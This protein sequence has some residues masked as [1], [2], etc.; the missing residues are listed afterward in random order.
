MTPLALIGLGAAI[1]ADLGS[2]LTDLLLV[3]PGNHDFRRLRNGDS[4]ALRRL[5]HNVVAKT[6]R[7]LQ[8]LAL[9]RCAVT[10]AVDFELA[11]VAV[12]DTLQDVFD[13]RAGHAPL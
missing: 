2:D 9:Q 10:N 11:L 4:D 8:V 5:I 3:D 12:L 6:E 1:F 13:H 7:Q